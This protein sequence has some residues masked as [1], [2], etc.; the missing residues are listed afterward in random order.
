MHRASYAGS[1]DIQSASSLKLTVRGA[2]AYRMSALPALATPGV[3]GSNPRAPT[4]PQVASIYSI[5][6]D[7]NAWREII[8]CREPSLRSSLLIT[9]NSEART[10]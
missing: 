8:V 10:V 9:A 6:K 2:F 5:F 7:E 1:A 4:I 3:G